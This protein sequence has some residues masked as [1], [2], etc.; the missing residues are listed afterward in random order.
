MAIIFHN[1]SNTIG[2]SHVADD[3]VV[4]EAVKYGIDGFIS[5]IESPMAA[6]K[7]ELALMKQQGFNGVF[8]RRCEWVINNLDNIESIDYNKKRVYKIDGGFYEF[9][10]ITETTVRFIEWM[11][12]Q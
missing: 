4:E 11:K 10:Q 7:A 12:A 9:K 5:S 2:S 1:I 3:N 8:M 6:K